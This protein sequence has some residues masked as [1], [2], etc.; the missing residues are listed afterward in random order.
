MG[1]LLKRRKPSSGAHNCSLDLYL[2]HNDSKWPMAKPSETLDIYRFIPATT[3][4]KLR[5]LA[6]GTG[7]WFGASWLYAKTLSM[8][9]SKL[10]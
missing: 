9:H 10:I 3:C 2:A 7:G 5:M 1:D 8:C 4:S 6:T